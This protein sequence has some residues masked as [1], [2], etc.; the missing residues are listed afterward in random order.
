[1]VD[2]LGI[3]SG[4]TQ[5]FVS[6]LSAKRTFAGVWRHARTQPG[7][8]KLQ[9]VGKVKAHQDLM[10]LDSRSP[11][12]FMAKG[13][14]DVDRLA[15]EAILFHPPLLQ[16]MLS[17]ADTAI[18]LAVKTCLL[19]AKAL[20]LWP[21]GEKYSRP[22]VKASTVATTKVEALPPI[23][24]RHRWEFSSGLH[25]CIKCLRSTSSMFLRHKLSLT[26][27]PGHSDSHIAVYKP[28]LGHAISVYEAFPIVVFACTICGSWTVKKPINLL[29]ACPGHRTPS[30]KKAL[31]CLEKGKHPQGHHL[32]EVILSPG[33]P[34][35]ALS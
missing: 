2:Y 12:Y 3:C 23:S 27:C 6:Q 28:G 1:M 29:K 19:Y 7:W 30:G 22:P 15:K 26:C 24:L 16:D 21:K 33:W 13:N 32:A 11:E 31:T 14:D 18:G 10:S 25:R 34:L 35:P 4:F 17:R 5:G 9:E 8:A 20:V